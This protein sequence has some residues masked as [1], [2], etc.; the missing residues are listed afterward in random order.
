MENA[1]LSYLSLY[2]S[3]ITFVKWHEAWKLSNFQHFGHIF[4]CSK[5]FRPKTKQVECCSVVLLFVLCSRVAKSQNVCHICRYEWRREETWPICLK[6][7]PAWKPASRLYIKCW[8]GE[9]ER[10]KWVQGGSL[11]AR[12]Y[13]SSPFWAYFGSLLLEFG[14]KENRELWSSNEASNSIFRSRYLKVSLSRTS[15]LGEV[16]GVHSFRIPEHLL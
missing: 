5:K 1:I 2:C 9:R 11:R 3:A 14:M 13:S 12:P 8:K 6:W 4:L 7:Q 16:Q 10:E 15:Q